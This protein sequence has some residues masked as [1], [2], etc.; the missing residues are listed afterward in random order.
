VGSDENEEQRLRATA[1]QTAES[2]LL[3]RRRAEAELLAAKEA[4]EAKTAELEEQRAWFEITLASIG[5]AVITTDVDGKV[6]FLNPVAETLTGWPLAE[7][8]GKA[9]EEIFQIV[10]EITRLPSPNPARR[11]LQ[12]AR[13]VELANHT[14]LISRSGAAIAIE[15]S[16]APIRSAR[17]E[18][19]GAV[20]VFHD[21]TLRRRAEE[22]RRASEAR[23][24]TTFNQAAVGIVVADL[25]G[26]FLEANDRFASMIGYSGSELRE[27]TFIDITHPE[28]RPRT[29]EGIAQLLAEEV[30]ECVLDKR[31]VRKDGDIFRSR[32]TVT[33]V[34]NADGRAE[35]FIGITE[36]IA[37]RRYSEE[38]RNRLA[39]VVEDS[40]DAIITKTLEGVITTWNQGATR[41]FG[42]TAAEVVG[43]PVTML[44]PPEHR[45]E[46]PGILQRLKRGERIDHYETVR[47]RKDGTRIDVSLTVSP[48]KDVD[49]VIIGAS[50]IA[51]DI[52]PQKRAEEALRQ[53]DRLKDEFVA[54]LAHELRN[55]LAPIRQA[56]L[57]SRSSA[58][59][60]EQKRWSHD[61]ISRQVHNMALLLDDLLD[62]SRVTSGTLELRPEESELSAI[63]EAAVETARP[64][65]DAKRHGLAIELPPGGVRIAADPLRLAQV[66]SN[67]LTNASKYTDPEGLI[68]L[69][70]ACDADSVTISV[71]DNG[72]GIPAD[73]LERI[74]QMFS[75][76]KSSQDRS[77]GGLG[78]G[79]A[80]TKGLVALHGGTIRAHSAGPGQGSEFVVHL[81]RR[82]LRV[83]QPPQNTGAPSTAGVRRRVLIADDN[84]DA[85][86]SLAILLQMD[87]HEVTVAHDGLQALSA[88]RAMPPQVVLLDIGMPKMDGYQ[89]ARAL[90]QSAEGRRMTL[91]AMTGWGQE[92]DKARAREAGFTHHFTKPVEPG[93]ILA[94]LRSESF[95]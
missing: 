20:M 52:S 89:V 64:M 21:V 24:R 19:C 84:R 76:V 33:L 56:A 77:E 87:G 41:V 63:I 22:A 58:A 82:A 81:P 94:L 80:L 86:E 67:L 18:V 3:A 16:A 73:A 78:I 74:F 57:I 35:Q 23:F 27:H 11:A 70:A 39:A 65:I 4:L 5:D 90:R 1:P 6:T 31:Y 79:L 59:T 71:A 29:R 12:E 54:T 68:R 38:L 51:R 46:E 10:N 15:D 62:I 49:G 7:A 95:A 2:V 60:E 30:P 44:I 9:L 17:G 32:T 28:D 69:R 91:I 47:L 55:P 83:S 48:I 26:R 34:K 25:D 13:S 50:K 75:Q 93:L 92:S 61:V 53:S 14:A 43:Q 85:A 66:F 36:D 8:R 37:D 42:Y 72:I 40:D 45:D 88:A